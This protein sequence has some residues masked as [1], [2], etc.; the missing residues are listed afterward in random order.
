M[1]WGYHVGI[2]STG[3]LWLIEGESYAGQVGFW[4]RAS[5]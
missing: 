5:R 2:T 3:Q 4:S 1:E